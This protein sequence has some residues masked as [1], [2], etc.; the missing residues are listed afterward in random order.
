M[1]NVGGPELLVILLVAL[2]VLGPQRLP[3]AART[4]GRVVSELRRVST[5]FQD[6]LRNA[7]DEA[8]RESG[9]ADTVP[10]ASTVAAADASG[11]DGEP[12]TADGPSERPALAPAVDDALGEIVGDGRTPATGGDGGERDRDSGGRRAEVPGERAAGG[13]GE[14]RAAS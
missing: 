11:R 2:I 4:V 3:E 13:D 1:F 6:E 9:E 10:L 7:L 12:A 5:G 8:E 14:R